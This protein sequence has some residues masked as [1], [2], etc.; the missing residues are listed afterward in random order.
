MGKKKPKVE[1]GTAPATP[2]ASTAPIALVKTTEEAAQ[3]FVAGDKTVLVEA[4]NGE[5]LECQSM[6]Q[7]DRFLAANKR[8]RAPTLYLLVPALDTAKSA[9]TLTE[10]RALVN[11][12]PDGQ[13]M[14]VTVRDTFAKKTEPVSKLVR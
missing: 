2:P 14:I 9:I 13:Y 12:M 10:A 11:D 4:K 1:A 7:I 8:G 5:L 3:R 6:E